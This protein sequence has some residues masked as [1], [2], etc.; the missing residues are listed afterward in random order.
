MTLPLSAGVYNLIINVFYAMKHRESTSMSSSTPPHHHRQKASWLEHKI[1]TLHRS[2]RILLIATHFL[3]F[4]IFHQALM[5][6][7]VSRRLIS[8]HK[9]SS[10]KLSEDNSPAR[11]LRLRADVL[12]PFAVV[13][14]FIFGFNSFHRLNYVS[15][16]YSSLSTHHGHFETESR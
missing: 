2:L 8:V 3:V 4:L 10:L 6:Q 12:L 15:T 11:K 5:S 7:S 16:R 9:W 13:V 14:F 1:F